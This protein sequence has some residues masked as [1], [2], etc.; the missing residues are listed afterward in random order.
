[1]PTSKS[2]SKC[3][4]KRKA[5]QPKPKVPQPP[6]L[7]I[8][9]DEEVIAIYKNKNQKPLMALPSGVVPIFHGEDFTVFDAGGPR[10]TKQ[11]FE[12]VLDNGLSIVVN[13]IGY[14]QRK[15]LQAQEDSDRK[16]ELETIVSFT[17][18]HSHC[19]FDDL[20]DE[21]PRLPDDEDEVESPDDDVPEPVKDV[22][23]EDEDP[24]DAD[25]RDHDEEDSFA[26]SDHDEDEEDNVFCVEE[27]E[28]LAA[29]L[30]ESDEGETDSDFDAEIAEVEFLQGSGKKKKKKKKK[31]GASTQKKRKEKSKNTTPPGRPRK[32]R[33][34]AAN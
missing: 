25:G 29:L 7:H 6:R 2:N 32:V 12:Y 9:D 4:R 16:V 27:D 31:A 8:G 34:S 23:E 24:N 20:E 3:S 14:I 22:D 10:D 19:G 15:K 28:T 30:E 5:S 13:R 33:S 26:G 1:M 11:L 18:R 21:A 17:G